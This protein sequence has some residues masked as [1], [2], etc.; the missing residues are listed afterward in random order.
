[1]GINAVSLRCS[2]ALIEQ[3]RRGEILGV[4]LVVQKAHA[5]LGLMG[6]C[7]LLIVLL[8]DGF[9]MKGHCI[10]KQYMY[11]ACAEAI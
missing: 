11:W 8:F 5:P 9:M 2:L 6:H 4:V 3:G 1:M 10:G 7:L